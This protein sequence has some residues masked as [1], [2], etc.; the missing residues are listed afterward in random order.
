V[1]NSVRETIIEQVITTLSAGS[2]PAPVSRSN[3]FQ[4]TDAN[5]SLPAIVV[6]PESE[7]VTLRTSD[8]EYCS[9]SIAVECQ[10]KGAPPID[11]SLDPLLVWVSQRLKADQTL[12]GLVSRVEEVET[13]WSIETGDEDAGAAKMTFEVQYLRQ[14][15]DPTV[16]LS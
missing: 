15:S 7:K 10:A 1:A 8:A 2:P 6:Y 14:L 11:Q 16:N 3:T 5:A 13:L 12:G 9:F 4:R